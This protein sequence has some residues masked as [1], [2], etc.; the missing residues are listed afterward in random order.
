MWSEPLTVASIPCLSCPLP[1]LHF[2]C[3]ASAK[4]HSPRV[5]GLI[6]DAVARGASRDDIM[7][8]WGLLASGRGQQSVFRALL[9]TG[10]GPATMP[11]LVSTAVSLGVDEGPRSAINARLSQAL[12]GKKVAQ[13]VAD[14]GEQGGRRGVWRRGGR[15]QGGVGGGAGA[16]G[17]GCGALGVGC[18]GRQGWQRGGVGRARPLELWCRA[19]VGPHAVCPCSVPKQCA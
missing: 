18:W 7:R 2:T 8:V 4:E 13:A 14:M 5:A 11:Q 1:G 6:N 9:A 12:R 10:P 17:A 15:C 3:A 19:D 16:V